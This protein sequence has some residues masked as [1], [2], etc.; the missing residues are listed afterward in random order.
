MAFLL[1]LT[2]QRLKTG[3]LLL[4]PPIDAVHGTR[5]LIWRW[6]TIF[7]VGHTLG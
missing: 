7:N 4:L 2:D 5:L 1:L 6:A 3:S